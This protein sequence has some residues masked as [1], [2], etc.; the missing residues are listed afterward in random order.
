[1][2]FGTG[3]V[4]T[5]EDFG[6]QG[7]YP[8]HPQLLEWLAV[9]FVE[10]GW[11]IQHMLRLMMSSATYT[12]ASSVTADALRRDPAN[13]W[14]ARG[15]RH[16][17]DAEEIRDGALLMGGLLVQTVG[18]KGV[19]P[20]Q[21]LG[22]WKAVGYTDSNTANFRRDNGNAL[23]R[24][25]LYTFWKR[26]APP[27]TMSLLDAPSREAC[28]VRRGRTNTPLQALAL[29]ND[30]QFVEAARGFGAQALA[31]GGDNDDARLAWMWRWATSRRPDAYELGVM[32]DLLTAERKH[33]ATRAA[34]AKSLIQTGQ[35]KPPSD[36]DATE[37]AA[38]ASVANM[39]LNLDETLTKG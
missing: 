20:Y 13:K 17:L 34:E 18:G 1:M 26:T 15:P 7:T 10:S 23:W 39:V 2:L 38:W 37:L 27:P 12:Q 35:S 28:S 9:E 19:R 33:Y 24:R 31:H 11:D 3:L 32:R 22:I 14:L 25:S 16:R 4:A 21:P 29:M 5:P 8:T 36:V 6:S 30:I